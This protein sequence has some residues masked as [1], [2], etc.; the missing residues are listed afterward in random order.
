VRAAGT[1][2]RRGGSLGPL[3]SM[4]LVL[5]AVCGPVRAAERVAQW[6]FFADKGLEPL[7][8]EAALI[9]RSL[10]LEPRALERRAR[11]RDDL[12]VDERDLDLAAHYVE[13]VLACG[14]R[15]RARSRWLNALSAEVDH[16]QLGCVEALPFVVATQPVSRRSRATDQPAPDP[17]FE[18]ETR[19]Y[20]VA[21]EQLAMLGAPSLHD[22]GL[23]GAGVVLGVL[24]TGFVLDHVSLAHID[25]V[26]EWDFINDDGV[27]RNDEGDPEHQHDH[28]TSVLS[29]IV[30]WDEGNF[31][32]VAPDVSVIL[33][34]TED[35]S[36]EEPVEEDW[37][38]E[39][40]EWVESMGADLMTASLGYIDWYELEDMD[41]QTAVTSQAAAVA[42]ANGLILVNSAGNDGP[43]AGTII[44][45]ADTDGLIAV[46]AVDRLGH[47]AGFSSR[48]PTADGR[49]KPD[50]SAMGVDNWVVDPGSVDAYRQGNGTSYAAP[51]VAGV[52]ALLLQAQPGTGPE[53]MWDLLTGTATQAEAP[54]NDYGWGIV[55]GVS[56]VGLYCTCQDYDLD[57]YY[58]ADCGGADCDDFRAAIHPGAEETCD[59][60]DDDCDG[61]LLEGEA[62]VDHD[63]YLA[64]SE[65]LPDCDDDDPASH[66][67]GTEVAYDGVDQ[68]CDGEDL[69]DVDGD[70]HAGPGDD[71]DDEDPAIHPDAA[72]QCEDL[73]DNDCDGHA[74]SRDPDCFDDAPAVIYA[75]EGC[76]CSSARC[77]GPSWR[78]IV[79]AV[80][81]MAISTKRS[82]ITLR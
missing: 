44:A 1:S 39:G 55:S 47:V 56:A 57:G 7:E 60:F 36:Q 46:G 80:L 68:D 25:V 15:E 22:C 73:V 21:E 20:G 2:S 69:V 14:A 27:V 54:D 67:G 48:G 10:E 49:V 17:G 78:L 3:L 6:V 79:A 66:P 37:W 13:A 40:L 64:C 8:V 81:L 59:G 23:T 24:D 30:G 71:C 50:V 52:V 26:A 82:A 43:E 72:E 33:C 51:M 9:L 31:G 70:G 19:D 12:G 41:G 28:G 74:D 45:P 77:H 38:V 32:G 16:D 63:G 62:D 53:A 11:A 65:G 4:A 75:P 42:L 34:K 35:T 18:A 76:G 61:L 5:C 29:L 58:D